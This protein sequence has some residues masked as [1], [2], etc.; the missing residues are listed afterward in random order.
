MKQDLIRENIHITCNDG[1]ELSGVLLLPENPKGLVQFN[2]GT[3]LRKEFYLP[4]LE[5]IA[6]HGYITCFY[7]YR[8]SGASAP[9]TLKG[10]EYRFSDYGV[11]DM[12]AVK[13]YLLKRYPD[14]PL[15]FVTH[16]VGGQQ[17]G[18]M[19]DLKE[20]KGMIG[21]AISTGYFG[22]MPWKFRL[23]SF[24]LFYLFT[25]FSIALSG[26]VA[27]KRFN[28]MEDLPKNVAREW[29]SWCWKSDYFFNKRFYGK[30][31]PVGIFKQYNFPI[32]AFWTTDDPIA[33]KDS[34]PAYWANIK[35]TKPITVRRLTPSEFGKKK[36]D[37][38]GFFKKAFKETLWQETVEKLNEFLSEA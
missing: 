11:K 19:P 32:H 16:S 38:M 2:G 37:H 7:D 5:F 9:A 31:V 8:G 30:T 28:Y 22:Y 23:K 34:V 3:A 17:I 25:P 21:F 24:Y 12:P 6:A 26:Y 35:S 15:L 14:L 10:C 1:I 36:I 27:A 18:F 20:V 13:T 4:F 33:N 29:R